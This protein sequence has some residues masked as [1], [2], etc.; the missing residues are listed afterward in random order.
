MVFIAKKLRSV[1]KMAGKEK[2]LCTVRE[3]LLLMLIKNIMYDQRPI[4]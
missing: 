2:G 1:F 4:I 3:L